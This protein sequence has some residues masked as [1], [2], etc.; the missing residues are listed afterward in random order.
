MAEKLE[1]I[2]IVRATVFDGEHA[3]RGA[4]LTVTDANRKDAN[5]LVGRGRAVAGAV[6][7]DSKAA[8]NKAVSDLDTKQA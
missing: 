7:F 8:A 4:V 3:D 1:K 5:Y 2:T 6:K